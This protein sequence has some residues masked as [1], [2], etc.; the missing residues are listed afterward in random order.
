MYNLQL[1][2]EN[3]YNNEVEILFQ[4]SRQWKDFVNIIRFLFYQDF[5]D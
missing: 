1:I 5:T 4:P 2:S 3:C